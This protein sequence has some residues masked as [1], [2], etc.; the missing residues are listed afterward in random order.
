MIVNSY[1]FE[2]GDAM[3]S[4]FIFAYAFTGDAGSG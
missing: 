2:D 4:S 1:F 3:P